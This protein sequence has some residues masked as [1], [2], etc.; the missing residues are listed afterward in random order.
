MCACS[1]SVVCLSFAQS[2]FLALFY[3]F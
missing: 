3:R 2:D 1:G